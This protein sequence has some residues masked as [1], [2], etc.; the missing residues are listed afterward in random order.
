MKIVKKIQMKIVIFTAVKNC[1]MLHGRVFVM[2][3]LLRLKC[4]EDWHSGK[5][6]GPRCSWFEPK[7]G[8]FSLWPWAIHISTAP[9]VIIRN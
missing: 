3:T 5:C 9:E 7:P 8:R 6:F 4:G 2:I 1:C